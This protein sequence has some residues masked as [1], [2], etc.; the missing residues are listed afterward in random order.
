MCGGLLGG[1][2]CRGT[3]MAEG[4]WDEHCVYGS[5]PTGPG[6]AVGALLPSAFGTAHNKKVETP[7]LCG[8]VPHPRV[9][10]SQA[11][12]HNTLMHIHS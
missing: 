3:G 6:A 1:R 11:H 9:Q 7:R 10:H 5:G 2:L 12:L 4:W 8:H